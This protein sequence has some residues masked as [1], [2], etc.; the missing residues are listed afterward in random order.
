[1]HRTCNLAIQLGAIFIS[2]TFL[3]NCNS[4]ISNRNWIISGLS[5]DEVTWFRMPQNVVTDLVSIGSYYRPIFNDSLIDSRIRLIRSD[6]YID[7]FVG[8]DFQSIVG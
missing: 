4:P 2:N 5:G 8:F 7:E 3:R 6:N 1:M